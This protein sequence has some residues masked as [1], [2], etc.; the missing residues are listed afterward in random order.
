MINEKLRMHIE[1][2]KGPHQ[3]FS[4][5]QERN[6]KEKNKFKDAFLKTFQMLDN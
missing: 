4:P 3:M 2:I 1:D 5:I 6:E